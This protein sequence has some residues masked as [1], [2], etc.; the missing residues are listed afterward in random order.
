MNEQLKTAEQINAPQTGQV[1]TSSDDVRTKLLSTFEAFKPA[2]EQYYNYAQQAAAL[3]QEFH[4]LRFKERFNL[5]ATEEILIATCDARETP[6]TLDKIM[7]SLPADKP[8]RRVVFDR[9]N[10]K[11]YLFA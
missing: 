8:I 7:A 1:Y 11:Y 2:L 3:A 10:G 4:R 6:P 9:L 5:D